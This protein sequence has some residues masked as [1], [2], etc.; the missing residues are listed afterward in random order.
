VHLP[1][2]PLTLRQTL[3]RLAR[4]RGFTSTVLVTL[5]LCIGANV[6]IFAAVDAILVRSLP[7][8]EPERLVSVF[9]AYPGAGVERAGASFPNYFERRTAISAFASTAVFQGGSATVGEAGSPRRVERDR[10]SP[11]FFST[12][13][14]PLAMGRTFTEDEMFYK[15]SARV[16]LTDSYWRNHFNADPD[17]LGKTMMVDSL[18]HTVV[19]VLP[20]G[21]RFLSSR[22][23]FFLP[24]ASNA[25]DRKADRRHSN[26]MGMIARLAPGVSQAVAQAQLDAFNAQQINEDRHADL[27]RGARFHT[28]VTSLHADHVREIRPMLVILQ[29]AVLFLLLIGAVNLVNL[30]LIRA[31][32]RA[33]DLAVRQALGA[34]G[35]RIAREVLLETVLLALAGGVIGLGVGALGIRLLSA[36]GTDRLPLGAEIVF[37]FRVAGMA[38][39][40]SFVVGFLL[41]IPV[42]WMSVR[43]R[44]ASVLQSE[45][46]T[47]TVSRGAQTLRHG[48]IVAQVGLAFVLL[49]GAGMLGL[50]LHRVLA[51]PPGFRPEHL[52]TGQIALPWKGYPDDDKRHAFVERLLSELRSQPGVSYVGLTSGLPMTGRISNNATTVEGSAPKPG[53]A[54]RSHYV[55]AVCGD[56]FKAMGIPLIEGRYLEEA[57]STRRPRVCVI[58]EDFANRYWPGQS[59]LGRRVSTNPTFDPNE[60]F[61]IV[62]VVG[63]VKQTGLTENRAQGTVYEPFKSR[64]TPNGFSLVLRTSV[65]PLSLAPVIQKVVLKL[66][67]ELPVDELKPMQGW[68]DESTISRRSPA[69]LAAIFAGVALLLAA[70]GTYGVLAY[71][72]G[73]RRREIGVRL[74][75]GASP[76]QVL[77]QFIGLGSRLLLVGI[78][79][80]AIGSWA[81]GRAMQSQLFGVGAFH[82]GVVTAAGMTMAFV[83]LAATLLPSRQAARVSPMEAL[84]DE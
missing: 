60:A 79:L 30:L 3:R 8:P 52:L 77:M 36:L 58:D 9:N 2:L 27:L 26:N 15:D 63:N 1:A 75:L 82:L 76:R 84:R 47:G 22:A 10:V 42:I 7:F 69:L 11:E 32:G 54:V 35:F 33:K 25:D 44:L 59:A 20:P 61:I 43:S 14:V 13:R 62:G 66:D 78:A 46:R 4:E 45:S 64:Y 12:L 49:A 51:T 74:A 21:F 50:S 65:D 34:S 29:G 37:D 16:I 67:P 73:Q 80:G 38:L 57:D 41:A 39:G 55:S 56:Y 6:A 72:V 5:A 70:V 81:V 24:L 28:K 68:I 48:F 53:D 31:S 40:L 18:P 83:V 23:Q 71:A 19:G 17:V